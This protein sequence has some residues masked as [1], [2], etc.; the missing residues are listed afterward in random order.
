MLGGASAAGVVAN[1]LVQLVAISSIGA[2]IFSGS[3]SPVT[4]SLRTLLLLLAAFAA[5]MLVQLIPLPY[6]IWSA[7]P[8][9]APIVEAFA[10]AAAGTPRLPI[11]LT[12]DATIAA[13]LSLLAPIA[14]IL[15]VASA[16]PA[17]RREAV[18]IMLGVAI[19]SVLLGSLQRAGGMESPLYPYAFTNRGSAV[20]L[21][22]NRNHLGTLLLCAL[23]FLAA[24]V[25]RYPRTMPRLVAGI[26]AS[27]IA[28]GAL[29]TGSRA[30]IG[31]LVPVLAG[32]TAI[33]LHGIRVLPRRRGLGVVASLGI[34]AAIA[35][36]FTAPDP[37]Q[38][39]ARSQHRK[40]I[41][42]ITLRAAI[43]HL[44]FGSGGGSFTAVYPA[45][46]DPNA[47]TPEYT[48]HAHD[49]YG[50]MLLE[51]GIPGGLL[52][53]ATVAAWLWRS[54]I[55]WQIPDADADDARAGSVAIGAILLHSAVD[56]PLRTAAIAAV[57][58]LAAALLVVPQPASADRHGAPA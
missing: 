29:L 47:V 6:P 4:P 35:M 24:T 1:G 53:A 56:Y 38:D 18:A 45:Y 25:R 28:A 36:A 8:G 54:W 15:V 9:R 16:S 52:V 48:N 23:P 50:E 57:A 42:A 12:P 46:E 20:G 2:L 44:P 40:A 39:P 17:G 55:V 30:A 21:F 14:M 37:R 19:L 3:L 5:V 33:L 7:L 51:F 43:D 49:D 13:L 31:L 11:S 58:G 10:L 26:G 27:V 22:A 41:T 34:I 32:C